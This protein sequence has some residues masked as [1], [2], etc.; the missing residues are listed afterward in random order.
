MMRMIPGGLADRSQRRSAPSGESSS[1]LMTVE[2]AHT[3]D[4]DEGHVAH[5]HPVH[6][7]SD[8]K[9][10]LVVLIT[11]LFVAG[12]IV[13]GA[14][15][16]SLALLSDAGHNFADAAAL[17]FSWYALRIARRPADLAMTFGYHRVGILA[18][19]V[20]AVSLVVI[21]IFIWWGAVDRLMQPAA[22]N[23]GIMIGVASAAIVLNGVIGFWLHHGAQHDLNVRG[24]YL[25]MLG[26]AI[27]A[28]GVVVAGVVVS[29]FHLSMADPLVSFLI[30][31]LILFSSWGILKE[32]VNVL[33]EGAP[34]KLDTAEV[35]RTIDGIPGVLG[36]HHLHV[37]TVG[38]GAVACSCHIIVAEQ[39]VREGQAICYRV[40]DALCQRFQIGH[41]TVQ[42]ESEGSCSDDPHCSIKTTAAHIGHHH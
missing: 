11:L 5:E 30:G 21:A 39:S 23:G 29:L 1:F 36:A 24:A 42:V 4:C 31:G 35:L 37:W 6:E 14:M 17:G 15:G 9:M 10:A 40:A 22:V 16:H 38:P 34:A 20:N 32:S 33:L 3:H 25:H 8:R 28:A 12:E 13:A 18:A 2:H 7:L 26:D 19:L 27:A 41:T